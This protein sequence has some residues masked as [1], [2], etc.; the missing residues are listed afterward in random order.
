MSKA[1]MPISKLYDDVL[2]TDPAQKALGVRLRAAFE[3]TTAA[4][5]AI[6]GHARLCDSNPTLRR[7]IEMRAPFI[8]PINILQVEFLRRSRE[9]PGDAGLKDA[10]LVTVRERNKGEGERRVGGALGRVP[11]LTTLTSSHSLLSPPLLLFPLPAASQVNG[12]AAG[13]KNTG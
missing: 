11:S 6:T 13:M 1:S 4:V 10:L 8:D 5:L 7:L 2:V 3:R 12:V 9:A